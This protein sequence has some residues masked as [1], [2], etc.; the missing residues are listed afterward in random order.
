MDSML[1]KKKLAD[2][3]FAGAAPA[4]NQPVQRRNALSGMGYEE[5]RAALSPDRPALQRKSEMPGNK[6]I[7]DD[8]EKDERAEY[9]YALTSDK[10]HAQFVLL[11]I[12]AT[13]YLENK[14]EDSELW[15]AWAKRVLSWSK[16]RRLPNLKDPGLVGDA[17]SNL[18]DEISFV[19]EAGQNFLEYYRGLP[20]DQMPTPAFKLAAAALYKLQKNGPK[21][22]A[23]K[24]KVVEKAEKRIYDRRH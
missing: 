23:K 12:Q 15:A 18:K 3:A 14:P 19:E 20:P 10:G 6:E 11:R 9:N 4:S 21:A 24:L 5:G 22:L 7:I 2:E 13:G 8:M 1:Q 16:S 17:R